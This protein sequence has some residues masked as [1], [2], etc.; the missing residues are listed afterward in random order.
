MEKSK[1]TKKKLNQ[2]TLHIAFYKADSPDASTMTHSS[3]RKTKQNKTVKPDFNAN[4]LLMNLEIYNYIRF[5]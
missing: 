1:S 4:H 3:N 5:F 2:Q